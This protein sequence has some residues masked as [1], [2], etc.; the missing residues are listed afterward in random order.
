MESPQCKVVMSEK[1]QFCESLDCEGHK[2]TMAKNRHDTASQNSAASEYHNALRKKFQANGW[3]LTY[4]SASE[5]ELSA[6]MEE[7]MSA[8]DQNPQPASEK[9]DL[10]IPPYQKDWADI[11]LE[12][13][14]TWEAEDG[15]APLW[16]AKATAAVER[17]L[18]QLPAPDHRW[19]L[20]FDGHIM[21]PFDYRKAGWK[22]LHEL[23]SHGC[24]LD[25]TELA[26]AQSDPPRDKR[27]S[28]LADIITKTDDRLRAAE[29][30]RTAN[31]P[32]YASE[33]KTEGAYYSVTGTK[34]H[35]LTTQSCD[36]KV[37]QDRWRSCADD[38]N[39]QV[40]D[41]L[42]RV[43]KT[44]RQ[45]HGPAA[46]ALKK[47]VRLIDGRWRFADSQ[48]WMTSLG[49]IPWD[50]R[51]VLKGK[52]WEIEIPESAGTL[53][54]PDSTGMRALC[55]ILMCNNI[56][57]PSGL[58]AD[59]ELLNE[60][61]TRPRHHKYFKATY[62]RP[63]VEC[64]DPGLT[65]VERAICAAM[66][67][68][69]QW[70]YV[71]DHIVT[72]DSELHTVCKLPTGKVTLAR[73][74]ALEGIRDFLQKQRAKLFFCSEPNQQFKRI[75]ADIEAGIGFAR[76]QEKLLAQV[77]TKSEEYTQRIQKA[78]YR[79]EK[80]L[81]EDGDWT[82]RYDR[83]ASHFK[84]YIRCGLICQYTGPYRWKIEG[85]PGTPDILDMA[86]DHIQYKRRK[87]AKLKRKAKAK[88]E[89]LRELKHASRVWIQPKTVFQEKDL[90]LRP[91]PS[92]SRFGDNAPL[93]V[94][95]G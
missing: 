30:I 76:K 6:L 9:E 66:R 39:K 32:E 72:E 36:G 61:L 25:S 89:A 10:C 82:T 2:T 77:Q 49:E 48:Q 69:A 17:A 93:S 27:F 47:V 21:E 59:G 81:E 80:D 65:E 45:Q 68:K 40:G 12:R 28:T 35:G 37:E 84:Q 74:D 73:A 14:R 56:A 85:L 24:L 87:L 29:L 13:S 88:T 1:G 75:L 71:A 63:R 90:E 42:E 4:S 18:F 57:C 51:M 62:R 91:I 31:S 52:N 44:I 7:K 34:L 86:A 53:I 43:F 26:V 5:Q 58:V 41:R 83:L 8:E 55:R 70:C 50:A 95:N 22:E 11:V 79:I 94:P 64:S 92:E 54:V 19:V 20:K 3:S 46:I 38:F 78:V 33:Q 16:L 15:V 23:I 60:F 67:L